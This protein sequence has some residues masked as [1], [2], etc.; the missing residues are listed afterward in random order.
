MTLAAIP[1]CCAN[2][3]QAHKKGKNESEWIIGRNGSLFFGGMFF[4]EIITAIAFVTLG[5]CR[6]ANILP[7]FHFISDHALSLLKIAGMIDVMTI[8][9]LGA[10]SVCMAIKNSLPAEQEK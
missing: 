1:A 5:L 2:T 4:L 8:S 6:D 7:S 9:F 10:T 3:I